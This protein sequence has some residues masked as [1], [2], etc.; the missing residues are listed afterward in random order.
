MMQLL[1]DEHDLARDML[2]VQNA[3]GH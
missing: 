2:K 3:R 1:R